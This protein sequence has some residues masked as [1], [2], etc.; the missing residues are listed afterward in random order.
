ML[1]ADPE[2]QLRTNSERLP[3]LKIIKKKQSRSKQGSQ[4]SRQSSSL[5]DKQMIPRVASIQA[6]PKRR[7]LQIEN[8]DYLNQKP[9]LH[10]MEKE[11]TNNMIKIMNMKTDFTKMRK[12]MAKIQCR[13]Q[14][15]RARNKSVNDSNMQQSSSLQQLQ[16][17]ED[18]GNHLDPDLVEDMKLRQMEEE[19]NITGVNQYKSKLEANILVLNKKVK[20]LQHKVK[21]GEINEKRLAKAHTQKVLF[22]E[23]Q[24][25][26]KGMSALR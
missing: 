25:K 18:F 7:S 11:L 24:E 19:F 1:A 17:K 26:D 6:W 12:L 13:P 14:K 10:V 23:H 4:L 16:R 15:T 21:Y 22:V 2:D 8:I 5:G 3:Q 20:E 9:S